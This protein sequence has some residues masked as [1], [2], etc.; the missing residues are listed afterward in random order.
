ME[1]KAPVEV[2]E[3]KD[4]TKSFPDDVPKAEEAMTEAVKEVTL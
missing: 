3:W 4:V 2:M 1:R